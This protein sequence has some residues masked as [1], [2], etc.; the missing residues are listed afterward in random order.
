VHLWHRRCV[1]GDGASKI[2]PPLQVM[3][4][5]QKE[6]A[7]FLR[8]RRERLKPADAGLPSGIRR[9]TPGLRREEVAELA[10]IGTGWYT[11]LEQG[12]DVRPSEGALRRIAKALQLDPTEQR[13]LLRLALEPSPWMHDEDVVTP[14]LECAIETVKGLALVLGR[15][16]ELLGYNE[17]ANAV[18]DIPYLPDRNWLRLLFTPEFHSFY[19]N[20]E[21]RARH[22]V[23]AFRAQHATC[24]RDPRVAALVGNLEESC[25]QFRAWW[26]EQAVRE[27]N[28]GHFTCDHP[29]VGRLQF[30][31]VLLGVLDNPCLRLDVCFPDGEESKRRLDELIRQRR[32]GQH[33]PEHNLWTALALRV[34]GSQNGHTTNGHGNGHGARV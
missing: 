20:W 12:R 9:R 2:E 6:L 19:P 31:F 29:F 3:D 11:F 27:E 30:R 33:G 13:Y 10:G 22:L 17:V 26:A 15:G 5:R 32:E 25:P 24:L 14:E 28:C 21:Q 8:S 1:V 34:R 16:W 18:F 4:R 23:G 7:S